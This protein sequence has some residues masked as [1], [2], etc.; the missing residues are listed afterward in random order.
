MNG[1]MIFRILLIIGCSIC[2]FSSDDK[3]TKAMGVLG[4]TLLSMYLLLGCFVR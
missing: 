3:V 1:E 4:I 2:I